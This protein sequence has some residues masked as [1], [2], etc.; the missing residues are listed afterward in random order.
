MTANASKRTDT[1]G[2]GA[3]ARLTGLTDHTIRVWERRYG[4]VIAE[5]AANGRRVYALEDVEKLGLLKQLTDS[6][7]SIGSIANSSIEELRSRAEQISEIATTPLPDEIRVAL[8]GDLLPSRVVAAEAS[9]APIKIVTAD[10]N[11]ERFAAD[12]ERQSIDVVVFE[13]AVLD[14]EVVVQLRAL[15]EACEAE[16]GVLVYSFGR[17]VDSAKLRNSNIVLARAPVS[18][19][20]V[21]AAV[22]RA[23][24][25]PSSSPARRREEVPATNDW[26]FDGPVPPRRFTQQQ[27]AKLGMVSTAIDCECPQHLA[28][29]VSG[30]SAFEIYSANC[31]N[32]NEEDAALHRY[33]HRTT[34]AARGMIESALE[35][36]A[37]AEGIN[38]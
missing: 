28:Q 26:N 33:L 9:L 19:D 8:V 29:L 13:T 37:E 31:A 5:R 20:E 14:E 12:L 17:S 18:E 27:L 34:A 23:Y 2:I 4:A 3:V 7:L 32:R 1:Y 22:V 30:L 16:R 36:V 15:M 35:R 11:L 10:N 6:G 24:T 38:F 21:Q 25:R